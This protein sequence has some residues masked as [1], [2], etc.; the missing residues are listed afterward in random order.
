MCNSFVKIYIFLR[1]HITS[2]MPMEATAA[3]DSTNTTNSPNV[4]GSAGTPPVDSCALEDCSKA[5]AEED[6]SSSSASTSDAEGSSDTLSS[7]DT[8]L[9]D[10]E[11]GAT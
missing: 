2:V 8:S 6:G 3:N 5:T 1:F 9:T 4:S 11:L 7:D 10:A